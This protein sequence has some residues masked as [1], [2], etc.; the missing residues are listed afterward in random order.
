MHGAVSA[1]VELLAEAANFGEYHVQVAL[2]FPRFPGCRFARSPTVAG[3]PAR[4][5]VLTDEM[6]MPMRV[7]DADIEDTE[8]LP[9]LFAS[10]AGVAQGNA[11]HLKN[12]SRAELGQQ[13]GCLPR[14]SHAARI[15][16]ASW[17]PPVPVGELFDRL[18]IR[19]LEFFPQR[20]RDRNHRSLHHLC[21]I[22]VQ[23]RGNLIL[24]HKVNCRPR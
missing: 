17:L 3:G 9:E 15:R 21:V 6:I 20:I 19:G 22:D 14:M 24:E 8:G 4:H 18:A 11:S 1:P 5:L 16:T 12:L 13:P 10:H 2:R 7:S 23:N